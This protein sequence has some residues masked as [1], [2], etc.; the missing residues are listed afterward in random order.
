MSTKTFL[1]NGPADRVRL[2]GV[3]GEIPQG[4]QVTIGPAKRT[5]PQNAALWPP[6]QEISE[7]V[8]WHGHVMNKE[9]WKE[10][11]TACMPG[12]FVVPGYEATRFVSIGQSS[13]QM[14][15]ERFSLLLELIYKFG[16][17]HGVIFNDPHPQEP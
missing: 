7:Q 16:A 5:T 9:Q 4:Y 3:V 12:S 14:D 6:L 17:E 13:S 15:K 10:F 11:F 2:A 8:V 1:I